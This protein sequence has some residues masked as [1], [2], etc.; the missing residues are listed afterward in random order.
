M[1]NLWLGMGVLTQTMTI[2]P[3]IRHLLAEGHKLFHIKIITESAESMGLS[4]PRVLSVNPSTEKIQLIVD[5][6]IDGVL[7][8]EFSSQGVHVYTR[9]KED[10]ASQLNYAMWDERS[11]YCSG[12]TT[13]FPKPLWFIQPYIPALLYLGEIRAYIVNGTM[14]NTV[15]TTPTTVNDLNGLDIQ[16]AILFTPLSK[17]RYVW[18]YSH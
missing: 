7:K 12:N 16:R 10:A 15:V 2:W 8:R 14:F 4:Y 11:A 1:E 6:D 3:D 18:Q 13:S 9:H 17:L 5:G